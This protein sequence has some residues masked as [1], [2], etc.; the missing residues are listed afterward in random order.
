V[1]EAREAARSPFRNR[2]T[3]LAGVVVA[4]ATVGLVVV[5]VLQ[6]QEQRRQR[7]VTSS[8]G[9]KMADRRAR[10]IPTSSTPRAPSITA[11][12]GPTGVLLGR[13]L[14]PTRMEPCRTP[15]FA[16]GSAWQLGTVAVRG[17]RLEPAYYCNLFRQGVGLL[18][19][20]VGRSYASLTVTIGFAEER[21]AAD[22]RVKF[23][24]IG[25][26]VNY[27]TGPRVLRFGESEQITVDLEET[28]RLTLR[29]T[30]VSEA[31]GDAAPSQPVWGRPVLVPIAS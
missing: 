25:D 26:G 13:A 23:E 21:S 29:V 3:T 8:S 11:S 14:R 17:A 12:S 31:A 10:L 24:L 16:T 15:T 20:D 7:Q 4:L 27:L 1:I 5:G 22:H 2:W 18:E 6:W 28:T 9:T 30:E 19:F